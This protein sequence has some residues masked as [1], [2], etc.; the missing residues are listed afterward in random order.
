MIELRVLGTLDLRDTSHGR[1]ITAVLA[2][3]KRMAL[4]AY[5]AVA[6]PRGPHNR[7]TLLPLFWPNS[8]EER[9]R[10]SLNQAVFNLRRSLGEA[11]VIGA[12]DELRVDA[13][14]V[15]CDAAEFEEALA[16]GDQRRAVSLYGGDLLPGFHVDDCI[17]FERWLDAERERL[18]AKALTA[19]L[20]LAG[21]EERSG[22]GVAA[23][24]LLRRAVVWSPYDEP[25]VFQ[26]VRLLAALGDRPGALREYERFQQLLEAEL[27]LAPSRELDTL[28]QKIRRGDFARPDRAPEARETPVSLAPGEHGA[29][30]AQSTVTQ[31]AA[32]TDVAVAAAP[33]H[34]EGWRSPYRKIA[35]ALALV[36]AASAAVFAAG[37]FT[38]SS[39]D[40]Q[41]IPLDSRRVL[42]AAFEN[43]TGEQVLDPF[44]YMAADWITQGLARSGLA[45]VVP[46][47]TVV[48]ETPHLTAEGS[49][50]EVAVPTAN[51]QFARRVGAGI[52]I[53]GAY[54]RAG[55]SL[56]VQTQVLDV[57]SGEL[58]RAIDDV[59]GSAAQPA[60]IVEEVQ[61]RSLGALAT[62][63]DD[64]L[65]SWPDPGG[66]P[67]S[68]E[69]YRLFSDGMAAFMR[70][71]SRYDTPERVQRFST[72]AA[73]FTAAA[74][75]DSTFTLPLLWAA[76]AHMNSDNPEAAR[77]IVRALEERPLSPWNSAVL[78]HL[79][80]ALAGDLER[81]YQASRE[82]VELSPDS[83]WL[84]KLA[85]SAFQT[86]RWR[87]ALTVLLRMDP[88]RGW[89]RGWGGY[90]TLRTEVQHV[91]GDYQA[92]LEDARRGLATQPDDPWLETQELWALAALGRVDELV[93]R[94]TPRIA[95]GDGYSL[96]LL[97]TVLEEL[98]GHGRT[99]AAARLGRHAVA[100][101]ES[102]VRRD[103]NPGARGHLAN[104]LYLAGNDRRAAALYD[105]LAREQPLNAQYRIRSAILAARR[106]DQRPATE[107]LAWLSTLRGESL[108]RTFPALERGYWGSP[109]GWLALQQAR[110]LAQL[111][112][113]DRA[114]E[115]L[116]S[117]TAQGL[118]H[119][120]L[121]LHD[122]PD[123]DP[124]RRHAGF[125]RLLRPRE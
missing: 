95:G 73:R 94:L 52:L 71:M 118:S 1:S 124:L 62:L 111:G 87:E 67:S 23:V 31:S 57:R 68:I 20:A 101:A 22:N 44:G 66:Q 41:A 34:A 54:Y 85:R 63:F 7:E 64:R 11:A 8:P 10:N 91:L 105:S 33:V 51:R 32:R 3:P 93:A 21:E 70:G 59:R 83:E 4:L 48:Q 119:T 60:S 76:Y 121:H 120:Y 77:E 116:R 78:N 81:Q 108:E 104:L 99:A 75:T 86:G 103:S 45:R 122:D 79:S 65:E 80:A 100:L 49:A 56:A 28:A 18:R 92:A 74:A 102:L 109:A 84:S 43:R 90:W 96:W 35:V 112:E 117:A 55:D 58:L 47:S 115:M 50:P 82:L 113:R 5:L 106:G 26:L 88:D 24:E 14:H 97:N 38:R 125:Q 16:A 19:A 114:V 98:R 40:D 37:R 15:W 42:V 107:T 12:G 39:A 6:T 46:F 17:E 9:A 27:A 29:L 123:F 2:Q 69:A 72:A 36:I 30:A 89:L 61:R 110:L 13:A 53:S 25:A